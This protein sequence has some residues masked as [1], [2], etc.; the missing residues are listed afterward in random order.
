MYNSAEKDN[1]QTVAVSGVI[2]K[3]FSE[4]KEKD[5]AIQEGVSGKFSTKTKPENYVID[6]ISKISDSFVGYV[7]LAKN[8]DES[9][10]YSCCFYLMVNLETISILT[11]PIAS[12]RTLKLYPMRE[13][14][15]ATAFSVT[16]PSKGLCILEIENELIIPIYN[17]VVATSI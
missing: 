5:I 1:Y 10:E 7:S 15:E 12:I 8:R 4:L 16:R 13:I 6:D 2:K 9:S 3:A 14:I 11:N 17:F